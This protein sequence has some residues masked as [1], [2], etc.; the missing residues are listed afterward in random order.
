[1][2]VRKFALGSATAGEVR[3][4]VTAADYAIMTRVSAANSPI[5]DRALPAL[6]RAADHTD[7]PFAFGSL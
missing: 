2:R 6:S 1:M 3:G 5:L 7:P 4:Q